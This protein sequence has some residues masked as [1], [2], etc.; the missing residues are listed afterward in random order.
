[1]LGYGLYTGRI[2]PEQLFREV[3]GQPPCDRS[4]DALPSKRTRFDKRKPKA[5]A[6]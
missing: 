1:V 4:P 6:C 3:L 2:K 5:E